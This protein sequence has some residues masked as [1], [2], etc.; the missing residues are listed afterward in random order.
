MSAPKPRR[1]LSSRTTA[2][3][4]GAARAIKSARVVD[5]LGLQIVSGALAPGT[6]LPPET[7]LAS[8]LGISRPSLREGLRALA[9]KGLVEARTRR[10]TVVT[11]RAEWDVLDPDVLRWHVS[12]APDPAFFM[13]LLEVRAIFE[14]AAAR[15]AA[16]RAAPAQIVGIEEAFRAMAASLP[17]DVEACCQHDLAFHERIIAASGNRLLVRFAVAIRTALLGAFRLS[18]NA[19]ASYENSLAE[20]WAVAEA[21]R[22][23]DA[24]AAEQA[25]HQLLA[26]TA[27]DLAPAYAERP[28][29]KSRNARKPARAPGRA[30]PSSAAVR[31]GALTRGGG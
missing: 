9:Q 19:R 30:A 17:G 12:V 1:L 5:T 25:M 28:H 16:A 21:I 24:A 18:S 27:R 6:L 11:E 31:G 26:G 10:G 13:D 23:R 4:Q 7:Q 3:A 8:R 14:P 29:G 15:I 2:P 20:H 22:R